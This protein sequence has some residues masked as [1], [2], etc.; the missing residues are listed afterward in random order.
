MVKFTLEAVCIL[1]EEKTEWNDAKK[2]LGRMDLLEMLRDYPKNNIKPAIIRK[3]DKYYKDPRF[4]P[5]EIEKVS[6]AAKCLCMWVRAMVNYDK[7]IKTIEPVWD[8][9]ISNRII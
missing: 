2:L 5:N 8:Q 7:V 3:L 6:V 9:L 4:T 1:F